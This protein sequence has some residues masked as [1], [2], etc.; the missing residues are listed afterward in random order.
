MN[1]K[2]KRNQNVLPIALILLLL[3]ACESGPSEVAHVNAADVEENVVI[4]TTVAE[5]ERDPIAHLR[6]PQKIF[7]VNCDKD[8]SF[9]FD[10]GGSVLHIPKDAFVFPDGSPVNGQVEISISNFR[11][12]AEIALSDIPMKFDKEGKEAYF[13]SAGMFSIAGKSK[14]KSCEI[15]SGKSL[16]IDYELTSQIDNLAFYRLND[17]K[18]GWTELSTIEKQS[19]ITTTDFSSNKPVKA[20]E[21]TKK[22]IAKDAISITDF[23]AGYVQAFP[24]W[25][26]KNQREKPLSM[27]I[28]RDAKLPDGMV[29]YLN[30]NPNYYLAIVYDLDTASKK[31]MNIRPHDRNPTKEYDDYLV[32]LLKA[33]PPCDAVEF[34]TGYE[35]ISGE[36][37]MEIH[38][39]SRD[40]PKIQQ[41][42]SSAADC[43]ALPEDSDQNASAQCPPDRYKAYRELTAGL[44]ITTFGTYN[45]D[46]VY[47]PTNM[48][49]IYATFDDENKKPILDPLTITVFDL[50]VNAAYGYL[51]GNAQV[52]KG[53]KTAIVLFTES[54]KV[55]ML[56]SENYRNQKRLVS[57][58]KKLQMQ[59]ITAQVKTSQDLEK[60]LK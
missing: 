3:C 50:N 56:N 46:G 23:T 36:G 49:R 44:V 9:V 42:K 28:A 57:S 48:E 35:L 51:P 33:L 43:V 19:P 4:P 29:D 5:E 1:V 22:T 32:N 52:Q 54:G 30:E 10:A 38:F 60:L 40:K 12:R 15:K 7:N 2:P 18:K 58:L 16:K 25:K 53:A 11:N 27:T 47:F 41:S 34:T 24:M 17:D 6:I 59:E 13:E 39:T 14:E 45:C 8:T 20:E 31:L 37:S 26:D 55:Y 21:T